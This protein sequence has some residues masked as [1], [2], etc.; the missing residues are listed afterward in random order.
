MPIERILGTDK[1]K[2]AF[3]KTDRNFVELEGQINSLDANKANKLQENY[4]NCTFENAWATTG[5]TS[6]LKYFKS[7]TGIV[8]LTGQ[9]KDGA[10]ASGT[11]VTTLPV[12]YRPTTT[13]TIPALKVND[14]SYIRL[15]VGADG[16]VKVFGLSS[17]GIININTSFRAA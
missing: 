9:A 16:T 2:D 12:G 15:D 1:G 4:I 17:T 6:G 8:Y 13:I 5:A 10:F 11:I 3:Y 7:T 14:S